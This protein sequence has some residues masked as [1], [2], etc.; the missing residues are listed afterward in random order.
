MG[1]TTKTSRQNRLEAT[2]PRP[3]ARTLL[4]CK[5]LGPPPRAFLQTSSAA[6][7]ASARRKTRRTSARPR[8]SGEFRITRAFW[9]LVSRRMSTSVIEGEAADRRPKEEPASHAQR[10]PD[11]RSENNA[12]E[13]GYAHTKLS[14][15]LTRMIEKHRGRSQSD[16][17]NKPMKEPQ[18]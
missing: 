13:A 10:P 3:S 2:F 15:H 16:G 6:S 8:H 18:N 14:V 9:R 7:S 11:V 1:R 5:R 4:L 17:R 12:G